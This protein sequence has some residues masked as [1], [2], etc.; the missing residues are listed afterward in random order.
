MAMGGGY[1][2]TAG[3]CPGA[4]PR[5]VPLDPDAHEAVEIVQALVP[6][7]LAARIWIAILAAQILAPEAQ[8]EHR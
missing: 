3:L 2:G 5:A 8:S 7:I 4:P 6:Q 1:R